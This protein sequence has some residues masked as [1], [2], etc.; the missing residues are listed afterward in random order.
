[1]T[2]LQTLNTQM[3]E[4]IKQAEYDLA[5]YESA[6]KAAETELQQ[7]RAKIADLEYRNE[8]LRGWLPNPDWNNAPVNAEWSAVDATGRMYWYAEKPEY[9]SAFWFGRTPI[10]THRPFAAYA[11]HS[12]TKRPMKEAAPSE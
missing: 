3:A 12:L 7:A 2:T 6:L 5:R 4:A 1:M 10:P 11:P 9:E 8:V